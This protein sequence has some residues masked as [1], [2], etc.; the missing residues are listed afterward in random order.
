[1][2]APAG[3][4]VESVVKRYRTAAG[5]VCAVDGIS[6]EVAPGTSVAVTGPSGCGK[7]TLLGLIGGLESPT[8]GRIVVD[9]R[10][11]SALSET[12]LL[13]LRRERFGFLFQADNLLPFLTA[14]ENVGLQLSLAGREGADDVVGPRALLGALGLAEHLDKLPD[15]L[16]GGQRQRVGVARA[17]VH[18]PGV[19]LADEPTGELDAAS[20]AE[21]VEV[22]LAARAEVGATLVLVT[23]DP[24]VAERMDR[25][26]T[27][28]DGRLLEGAPA[29]RRRGARARL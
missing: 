10:E 17:L 3:I 5:A 15:Q 21:V 24:G 4:R 25:I 29:R 22:I 23:H 16:S 18:R 7:S 26:V 14:T 19:I 9:G 6:L 20:S 1:V 27:L 8:S 12:E 2:S 11:I 28:R 13:R